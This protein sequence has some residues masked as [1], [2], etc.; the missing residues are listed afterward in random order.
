MGAPTPVVASA[1]ALVLALLLAIGPTTVRLL[2]D[3]DDSTVRELL[4]GMA[5][6]QISGAHRSLSGYLA[7]AT[8]TNHANVVAFEAGFASDPQTMTKVVLGAQA[9]TLERF[10]FVYRCYPYASGKW[11][12]EGWHRDIQ[13]GQPEYWYTTNASGWTH[14]YGTNSSK[15]LDT[16]AAPII[17]FPIDATN[18][19]YVTIPLAHGEGWTP[20]YPF[21]IQ[22][23]DGSQRAH[24]FVTH[25][26]AASD[27]QSTWN[28]DIDAFDLSSL[29]KALKTPGP[30]STLFAFETST[31]HL[32][33][34][35]SGLE[36]ET[37]VTT[38]AGGLLKA[39]DSSNGVIK[40]AAAAAVVA[41]SSSAAAEVEIEGQQYIL[42]SA[43][44]LDGS[45]MDWTVVI[46]LNKSQYRETFGKRR[47]ASLWM[48]ILGG[49]LLLALAATVLF[50]SGKQKS[51]A[52]AAT[53]SA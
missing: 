18:D 23:A 38:A 30:H 3:A 2:D 45:S 41:S 43:R 12:F 37:A 39:T 49:V 50:C 40:G 42:A 35:A 20:A 33:G 25:G 52:G 14:C 32:V 47:Q 16:S 51:T 11:G 22:Y 53:T 31:G 28:T 46:C 29:L 24:I 44:V 4:C 13:A 10:A 7:T 34:A 17:S 5:E 27:K 15:T 21:M 6:A 26:R 1:L 36:A 9:A 8:R 48:S 19:P